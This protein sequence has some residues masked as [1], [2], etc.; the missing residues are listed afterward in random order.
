MHK[1]WSGP[2][3][4]ML[5]YTPRKWISYSQEILRHRSQFLSKKGE[6][7]LR[8]VGRISR[9]LWEGGG[10]QIRFDVENPDRSGSQ[11]AKIV[12]N[13]WIAPPPPRTL[14]GN[15]LFFFFFFFFFFYKFGWEGSEERWDIYGEKHRWWVGNDDYISH[16]L[17]FPYNFKWGLEHVLF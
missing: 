10:S 3:S 12:K 5:R 7:I 8:E 16:L 9:N 11:F 13:I 6:K 4:H 2:F 1:I 15:I 14:Y 17:L